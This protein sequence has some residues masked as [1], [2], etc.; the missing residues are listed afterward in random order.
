MRQPHLTLHLELLELESCRLPSHLPPDLDPSPH[1]HAVSWDQS[2]PPDRYPI[3][4][5]HE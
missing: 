5:L 3:H 1:L 4:Y 2:H